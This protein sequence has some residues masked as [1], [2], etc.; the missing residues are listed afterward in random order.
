MVYRFFSAISLLSLLILAGCGG[1]EVSG[2]CMNNT[3]CPVNQVCVNG[4]CFNQVTGCTIDSQCTSPQKCINGACVTDS[5]CT[6]NN[7]CTSPLVC[8]NGTCGDDPY[9]TMNSQC[10]APLVCK[11]GGCFPAET[12]TTDAVSSDTTTLSPDSPQVLESWPKPDESNVSIPFTVKISFGDADKKPVSMK[13]G[14]FGT[15]TF[16]VT[17]V[18]GNVV[19]G[20]FTYST[21]YS[22]VTFTPTVDLME[23]SPYRVLLN[24]NIKDQNNT[25]LAQAH[26][27]TFYTELPGNLNT[28]SALATEF[29]PTVH[30]EL[31]TATPQY[32]I[33]LRADF[34]EDWDVS[35][36]IA[37]LGGE[38]AS[39]TPTLY[40]DVIETRTHYFITYGFYWPKSTSEDT[41]VVANDTAGLQLVVRKNGKVPEILTLQSASRNSSQITEYDAYALANTATDL[42]EGGY[43]DIEVVE[44]DEWIPKKG[45]HVYFSAG[46]HTP[47]LWSD[48]SQGCLAND[49][50]VRTFQPTNNPQ[51][52]TKKGAK[53]NYATEEGDLTYGLEH[54]LSSMWVRRQETAEEPDTLWESHFEFNSKHSSGEIKAQFGPDA[55]LPAKFADPPTEAEYTGRPFWAWDWKSGSGNGETKGLTRGLSYLDPAW[56]VAWRHIFKKSDSNVDEVVEETTPE[57]ETVLYSMR[58]CFHPYFAIDNRSL[59]E[60]K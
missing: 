44:E 4:A 54:V 42:V 25:P 31:D 18:Y 24:T 3:D 19:D 20:V 36:N 15:Q 41:S 2:G 47:C 50:N 59:P 29:A 12:S 33:P 37:A 52:V 53:W 23:A 39:V 49:A 58:Y 28:Y 26:T 48:K 7:D 46:A 43:S 27:F 10:E 30:L 35:N 9:C 6:S 14:S 8:I 40:W 22:D 56:Y 1:D 51:P 21:D 13:T 11:N 5:S 55:S 34:D 16:T 60:C 45:I 17:D 38:L 57:L 32:D